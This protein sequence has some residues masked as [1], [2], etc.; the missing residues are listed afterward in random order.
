MTAYSGQDQNLRCMH[1][2]S[3]PICGKRAQFDCVHSRGTAYRAKL[4]QRA[5]IISSAPEK[6][7]I[8]AIAAT[9]EL[10]RLELSGLT[11]IQK[12]KLALATIEA[13]SKRDALIARVALIVAVILGIVAVV[14]I[15]LGSS[16]TPSPDLKSKLI[17]SYQVKLGKNGGCNGGK[18][19]TFPR[20]LAKIYTDGS[21]LI[22]QNECGQSSPIQVSG[23]GDT[24]YFYG[25]SARVTQ[26][27]PNL[28]VTITDDAQNVWEKLP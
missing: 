8:D 5:Q 20:E 4:Q 26:A 17:G 3:Y 13:R 18:P 15:V 1:V 25:E 21:N 9:A 11:N 28:P 2:A 6:D 19:Y 27:A 23:W 16:K 24:I 14:S 22:A 12:Q 7:K 10:F